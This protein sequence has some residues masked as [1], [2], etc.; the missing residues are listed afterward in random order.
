MIELTTEWKK[1][2][3]S[4]NIKYEDHLD[5]ILFYDPVEHPLH[6]VIRKASKN[7]EINNYSSNRVG[8]MS[9]EDFKNKFN[10]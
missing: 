7:Q 4:K 9:F 8:K 2:L 6:V 1:E 3:D 5:Y 10:P